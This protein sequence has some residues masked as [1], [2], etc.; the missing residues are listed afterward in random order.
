MPIL[1]SVLSVITVTLNLLSGLASVLLIGC[2]GA[3][4]LLFGV[5]ALL[6]RDKNLPDRGGMAITVLNGVRWCR[7]SRR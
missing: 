4:L 5:I 6:M 3:L 7:V 2:T 1:F